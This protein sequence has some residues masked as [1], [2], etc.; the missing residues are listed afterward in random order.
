MGVVVCLKGLKT[1][2]IMDEIF[3]TVEEAARIEGVSEETIRRRCRQGKIK[4]QKVK[5]ER[6]DQYVIPRSSLN[7]KDAQLV[8]VPQIPPAM[9]GQF[10][11][12]M[13]QVVAVRTEHLE[14]K[15][16]A[17]NEV[18]QQTHTTVIEAKEESRQLRAELESHFRRQDEK[19]TAATNRPIVIQAP[20][21]EKQATIN[22]GL[23]ILVIFCV[24]M[25][26]LMAWVTIYRPQF[27]G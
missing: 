4:A 12:V 10:R 1:L 5:G 19:I 18:L 21:P 11:E 17:Q 6:G 26:G 15:I 9:L 16:D 27:G 7:T 23:I 3:T 2:E 8:T 24:A 13:E 20:E 14:Q 22:V 25:V